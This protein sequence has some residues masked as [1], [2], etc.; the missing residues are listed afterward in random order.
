VVVWQSYG[1]DGDLGGIFGQLFDKSGK[2]VGG[3]FAVNATA[4]GHQ[5]RPQVSFLSDGG[6]AVGWTTEAIADDPGA[7]SVRAFDALGNPQSAEERVVGT[8]GSHPNLGGRPQPAL[9]PAGRRAGGDRFLRPGVR[10]HDGSRRRSPGAGVTRAGRRLRAAGCWLL[11]LSSAAAAQTPLGGDRSFLIRLP[12]VTSESGPSPVCDGD[13]VCALFWV[14]AYSGAQPPDLFAVT[15]AKDGGLLGGPKR[16]AAAVTNSLLH[17]GLEHGFALLVDELH[18]DGT[19]TASPVLRELDQAL[20]EVRPPAELPFVTGAPPDDPRS[21]GIFLAMTRSA[22][23]YTLLA[24]APV[25][26]GTT[27]A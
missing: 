13:G 4:A 22:A 26:G 2:P 7:V 3:E 19:G 14:V 25:E 18:A 27:A 23:G 11:L 24:Q 6:F 8:S 21:Y 17:L 20:R 5:A 10:F 9:V 12:D 15:L 16:V 1:Q